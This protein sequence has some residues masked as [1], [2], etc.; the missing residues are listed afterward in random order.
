[1]KR[2]RLSNGTP[3]NGTRAPDPKERRKNNG[4]LPRQVKGVGK[5][6]VPTPTSPGRPKN[7]PNKITAVL[8]DA[9]LLAASQVGED[10]RGKGGLLGYLRK[11]ARSY[12]KTYSALLSRIIPLQITGKN[13]GPIQ[14][15]QLDAEMLKAA[16]GKELETLES[17]LVRQAQGFAAQRP[18]EDDDGVDEDLYAS[19]LSEDS[20]TAGEA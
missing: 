4:S 20:P 5:G 2:F 18:P 7:V 8:K 16:S 17:V 11:V 9:I 15:V 3:V 6:G 1:M 12:P 14:Y 10:D 13:D 19:T